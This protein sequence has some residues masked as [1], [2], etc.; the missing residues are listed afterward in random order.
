MRRTRTACEAVSITAVRRQLRSAHPV[1]CLLTGG[2]D[3]SSVGALAARALAEQN[4]RLTAFTGVPRDGFQ[5]Q[6]PPGTYA[7][8]TPY[9]EAIARKLGNVDVEYVRDD[10]GSTFA[11]LERVFI[12]LEAPVRNPGISTGCWQFCSTRGREAAVSCSADCTAIAP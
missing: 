7:D 3:S 2:L 4:K 8:E 5:G 10:A 12:A 9:V 11:S 6:L 1:G